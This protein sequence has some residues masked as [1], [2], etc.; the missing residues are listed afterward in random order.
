MQIAQYL[1]CH[2]PMNV[3]DAM[4]RIETCLGTDLFRQAFPVILTDNGQ[5]F[6]DIEGMERSCLDPNRRRTRIFFCEPNRSDQKGSCE[7]NHKLI[8]DV[9]PKGTSLIPFIQSDITLMM[10]H[11]NSYRRKKSYGF[12]AYDLA[13]QALP[14]EF[15]DRM[16]LY[17]VPDDKVLLKPKLLKSRL[18]ERT[19][20]FDYSPI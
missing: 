5:E 20:A 13:M 11:I 1:D 2:D 4:D 10:N 16:G 18:K 12:C 15:F 7:N 17:K 3:V 8:R 14:E 19:E 9:L 6:S